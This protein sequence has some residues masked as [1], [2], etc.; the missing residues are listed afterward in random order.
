MKS[1]IIKIAK[2]VCPAVVSVIVSK[3]LPK[4][5]DFYSFPYGGKEYI[6][7]MMQKDGK[8]EIERTEIGGDDAKRR[9][10]RN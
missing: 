1:P 2:K 8:G 7:P 10:G 4:V 6:M 9:E 3:D 5:E